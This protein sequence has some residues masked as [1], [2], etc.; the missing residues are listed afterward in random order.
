MI[1]EQEL[2]E[3]AERI[4]ELIVEALEEQGLSEQE[5]NQRIRSANRFIEAT[6]LGRN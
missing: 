4:A 3:T 1:E 2:D 5:I 6:V